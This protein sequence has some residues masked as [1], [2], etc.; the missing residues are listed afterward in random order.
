MMRAA[1]AAATLPPNPSLNKNLGPRTI[2]ILALLLLLTACTGSIGGAS[3]SV[4]TTSSAPTSTTATVAHL[5]PAQAIK[6]FLVARI[7]VTSCGGKVFAAY[8]VMGTE[9]TGQTIKLYLWA[10]VQEYCASQGRLAAG[11]GTSEPVVIIVGEQDGKYR[12]ID[13]KD[14][15][16]GYQFLK[17]NF[18]PAI[19]PLINLPADEYNQRAASLSRETKEAAE[20]YYGIQK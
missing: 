7:G 10:V 2:L 19:L 8:Q 9:R 20:A 11:T 18:P 4:P 3:V 16:E 1:N 5:V 15:G 6:D 17:D 14:A 12:L 13:F